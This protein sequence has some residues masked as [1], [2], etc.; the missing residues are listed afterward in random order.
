M[1]KF[2]WTKSVVLF[3]FYILCENFS[4]IGPLIKII[5]KFWDDPLH[6][7]EIYLSL[8]LKKWKKITWNGTAFI[9]CYDLTC[10]TWILIDTTAQL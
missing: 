10:N 9:V 6:Y 4:K 2:S 8:I 5:P 3:R 7:F 1:E